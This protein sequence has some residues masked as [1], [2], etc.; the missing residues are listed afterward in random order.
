LPVQGIGL[1]PEWG[2]VGESVKGLAP[3]EYDIES[4]EC[5]AIVGEINGAL[6]R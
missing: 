3:G 2:E 1:K 6:L 4:V 5:N